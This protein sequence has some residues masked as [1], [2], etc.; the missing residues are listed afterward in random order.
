MA[1]RLMK[2]PAAVKALQKQFHAFSSNSDLSNQGS[3]KSPEQ[4]LD[5]IY[6]EL[7]KQFQHVNTPSDIGDDDEQST[8][9]SK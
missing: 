8:E 9:K 7:K 2:D 6:K 4:V 5:D 3:N 1:A